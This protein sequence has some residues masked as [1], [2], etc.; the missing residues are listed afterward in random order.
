MNS[1]LNQIGFIL[2]LIL[3][4]SSSVS[5]SQSKTVEGKYSYLLKPHPKSVYFRYNLNLK[6]DFTFELERYNEQYC[7]NSTEKITGSWKRKED[8]ILFESIDYQEKI[9]K[10]RV[11]TI[12]KNE[13]IIIEEEYWKDEVD[14]EN[15]F[16]ALLDSDY[17]L[18]RLLNPIESK[19]VK[20]DLSSSDEEYISFEYGDLVS[21]FELPDE[22]NIVVYYGERF[23]DFYEGSHN[24]AGMNIDLTSG[25]NLVTLDGV[26]GILNS[27]M[28]LLI[29][30]E[31]N[32]ESL[33][34]VANEL[35]NVKHIY[36]KKNKQ[37]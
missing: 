14:R 28:K 2:L 32:L 30:D 23:L 5:Y 22:T 34:H 36:K 21:K 8:K 13:L 18:L 29:T 17:N 16:L 19:L 12:A 26:P 24:E 37:N 27:G 9:M 33:S 1:K 31:G 6:S 20:E 4:F 7:Y 35:G 10:E 25:H 11:D 15:I 3:I